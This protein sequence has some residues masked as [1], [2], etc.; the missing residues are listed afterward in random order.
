MLEK[1]DNAANTDF[2]DKEIQ[3]L[4]DEEIPASVEGNHLKPRGERGEPTN[5]QQARKMDQMTSSA[6]TLVIERVGSF[7]MTEEELQ[8]KSFISLLSLPPHC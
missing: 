2:Q 5:T 6:T 8:V 1:A 3:E 4:V 7:N